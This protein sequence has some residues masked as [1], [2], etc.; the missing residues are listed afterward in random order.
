MLD[1]Q[2]LALSERVAANEIKIYNA[3]KRI[4]D[5]ERITDGIH[6][7]A[8]HLEALAVQV[9]HLSENMKHNNERLGKLEERP[10]KRWEALVGQIIT[11]LVASVVGGAIGRLL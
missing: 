7:I 3:H 4:D 8:S 2:L 11:L 6:K 9:T 1:D 5:S 10:A